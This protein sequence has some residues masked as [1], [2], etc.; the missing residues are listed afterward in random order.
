MF[1][2]VG[3][4]ELACLEAVFFTTLIELCPPENGPCVKPRQFLVP[5]VSRV[6]FEK[7]FPRGGVPNPPFKDLGLE[8]LIYVGVENLCCNFPNSHDAKKLFHST[9]FKRCFTLTVID[10]YFPHNSPKAR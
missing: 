2:N 6:R 1:P 3:I 9:K 10:P 5:S 4:G 8:P 7:R